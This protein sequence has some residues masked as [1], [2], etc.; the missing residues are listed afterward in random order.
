MKNQNKYKIFSILWMMFISAGLG[1][2][3]TACEDDQ[4]Y[5]IDW[6]VP[7][8]TDFS[9]KTDTVERTVTITGS[10]FLKINEVK[11]GNTVCEITDT[12]ETQIVVNIPRFVDADYFTITNKYKQSSLTE[13]V[14]TPLFPETVITEWPEVLYANEKFRIKGENVDL[15]TSLKLNDST[16][17]LDGSTAIGTTILEINTRNVGLVI[18]QEYQI[19]SIVSRANNN[20]ESSPALMVEEA[21]FLPEGS[22]PFLMHDFEDG[23]DRYT[24]WDGS[25]VNGEEQYG[26]NLSGL[27]AQSPNG[28]NNFQTVRIPAIPDGQD[29]AYFG[30]V[31]YGDKTG[32]AGY[33]AIDLSTF[34]DPYISMLVN[35]NDGACR[36][37]YEVYE[38]Q[39]FANHVDL[40]DTEGEWKWV[41]I[42]IGEDVVFQDWGSNG[43][44]GDDPDGV[45]DYSAIRYIQIGMGTGDVGGGNKWEINMDN[46][47]ITDGPVNEADIVD[48]SPVAILWDFEDGADAYVVGDWQSDVL[49]SGTINGGGLTAPQGSNYLEVTANVV[50]EGWNW[51]GNLEQSL[52]LDLSEYV[53]PHLNF[54]VNTAGNDV[55][56]EAQVNDINEGSWGT[57]F[58]ANGDGWTL[59]SINLNTAEF[60]NWGASTDEPD[61][62]GITLIK[63]GFNANGQPAG[64]YKT[65]VDFVTITDGPAY[66]K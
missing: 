32:D 28:G 29:W 64:E 8:V 39:K 42:P 54:Y 50:N 26:I 3:F 41:S 47:M 55:T 13:A 23:V 46:L 63:V 61:F 60:G 11:L 2:V 38:S 19:T 48:F 31:A 7:V 66:L 33:E 35:T 20:I 18:G 40:I 65:Y 62:S 6:P 15:I 44:S 16:Y 37:M 1:T 9:P 34:R 24:F 45:L 59:V 36:L 56:F 22:D 30:E 53:N 51:Y 27:D 58:T 49:S 4:E 10:N 12:S 17:V 5:D 14:F 25:P 57:N 52:N 21:D 43:W